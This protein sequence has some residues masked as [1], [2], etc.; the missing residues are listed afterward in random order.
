MP[1]RDGYMPGVPCW[2]DTSQPDPQAAVTF[3]GGLFGWDM[4]D[5]SPQGSP[6]S[7]FIARLRDGDVAA[8]ASAP[9][10]GLSKATWNTYVWVDSA[11]STIA[12][13]L[14]A[15][16]HVVAEPFD[17]TN[18][19]RMAVLADPEGAELRVW[20]AGEHRGAQIVNEPGAVSFNG[21]N[22]RDVAGA[23]AFY[24]AVFG[25]KTLTM[26]GGVEA[27]RLPGYGDS[28]EL[29]DPG[30]RKRMAEAGAPE[31]FEDVVATLNPI[32]EGQTGVPAHW[33]VTFAVEDADETAE[34]AAQLGGEVLV[35]PMDAPWVRMTVIRDPRGATFTAARFAPE[36][37][38]LEYDSTP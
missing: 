23:K 22:T 36:N 16:G 24:G 32:A 10:G 4:Q 31:G 5:V 19:G 17:V 28:L 33:D 11:E 37:A 18:A 25:W 21:L 26:G 34:R 35:A 8:I 6:G 12:K 1:E 20:E 7:Y 29:A 38:N 3:Y 15:G 9:D 27:W 2:T 13:A 14:D 30:L